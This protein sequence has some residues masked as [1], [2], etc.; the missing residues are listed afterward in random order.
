[1]ILLTG[2]QYN[3]SLHVILLEI[4]YEIS[5]EL[6]VVVVVHLQ[7]L[8]VEDYAEQWTYYVRILVIV[9]IDFHC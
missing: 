1:M 6:I 2:T 4:G 9:M 7:Q 5:D 3:T 8:L